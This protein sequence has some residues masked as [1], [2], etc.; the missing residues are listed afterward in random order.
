MQ[1]ALFGSE[2]H[3]V[4]LANYALDCYV[5]DDGTQLIGKSILEKLLGVESKSKSGLYDFFLLLNKHFSIPETL[6]SVLQFPKAFVIDDELPAQTTSFGYDSATFVM[7]CQHILK[8]K[9]DGFLSAKQSKY[10]TICEKILQDLEQKNLACLIDNA[11][12]FLFYKENAKENF[13]IFLLKQHPDLAFEWVTTFNDDFYDAIFRF[14]NIMW[15]DFKQ[16]PL[17]LADFITNIIFMRIDDKTLNEIR[18][19]KPK[20]SYIN[21]QGFLLNREHPTLRVYNQTLQN[22]LTEANYERSEFMQ[23]LIKN[24]PKNTSRENYQFVATT[25]ENLSA[26]N[27]TLQLGLTQL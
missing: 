7:I 6:L 16:N 18:A 21:K 25:A 3:L 26:F 27:E 11:S 23:L 19:L 5:L 10:G 12:G 22:F 1:K 4:K 13:K 2:N 15:F 8:A 9:K 24:Y 20:R 14:I 17:L